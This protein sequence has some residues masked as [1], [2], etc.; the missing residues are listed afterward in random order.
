MANNTTVITLENLASFYE[1]LKTWFSSKF[2]SKQEAIR[3]YAN[4]NGSSAQQFSA[5]WLVV[6]SSDTVT[7]E[8]KKLLDGS[9]YLVLS[10]PTSTST[11]P[12][13]TRIPF[14]AT[15]VD[16][17]T[18]DQL[19]GKASQVSA[20]YDGTTNYFATT[21]RINV[22]RMIVAA[23][24]MDTIGYVGG[25]AKGD[26]VYLP[27]SSGINEGLYVVKS[28]TGSNNGASI[29]DLQYIEKPSSRTLYFSVDSG[30]FYTYSDVGFTAIGYSG[31][32]SF[33]EDVDWV[34]ASDQEIANLFTN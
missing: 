13:V 32:G 24:V 2:L 28:L 23:N 30:T 6:G 5:K 3:S 20:V 10:I 19:N 27:G 11:E 26:V 33:P 22:L 4:I 8:P 15:D 34:P 14:N 21:P 18:V 9:M 31:G 12:Y 1:K 25:C 7:M 29:S 17:A 16:V